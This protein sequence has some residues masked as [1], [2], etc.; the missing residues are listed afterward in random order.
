MNND[1]GPPFL[2]DVPVDIG[3]LAEHVTEAIIGGLRQ[4]VAKGGL[5][6]LVHG[7]DNADVQAR[8]DALG[9]QLSLISDAASMVAPH[10]QTLNEGGNTQVQPDLPRDALTAVPTAIAAGTTKGDWLAAVMAFKDIDD[11][12][13]A[14]LP[15]A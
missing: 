8:L 3:C 15:C 7:V 10:G 6:E 9:S 11:P 4:V 5:P 13:S 1:S 2:Q 12:G 14:A